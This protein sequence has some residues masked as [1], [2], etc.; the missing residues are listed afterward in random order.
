MLGFKVQL[1]PPTVNICGK[2]NSEVG[3]KRII[4]VGKYIF[5]SRKGKRKDK[6]QII[7]FYLFTVIKCKTKLSCFYLGYIISLRRRPELILILL[8]LLI[9]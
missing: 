7:T 3:Y 2:Y 9:F 6:N 1:A 8:L 4:S 5:K